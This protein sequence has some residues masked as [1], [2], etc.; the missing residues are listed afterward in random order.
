MSN[1]E[2]V[3]AMFNKN[4]SCNAIHMEL[5][6]PFKEITHY[7]REDETAKARHKKQL[8]ANREM[9]LYNVS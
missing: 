3:T 7:I 4:W 1:K 9:E 5:G 8:R 6:L 2:R